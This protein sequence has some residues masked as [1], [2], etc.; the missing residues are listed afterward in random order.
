MARRKDHTREELTQLAI[1]CGREI[2]QA[3]GVNALTARNVAKHMH[4]APGTLYNL[5]ENID[6]LVAAINALTLANL[7]ASIDQVIRAHAKPKKRLRKIADVYMKL[8]LQQPQLWELLL[9]KPTEQKTDLIEAAN[10]GILLQLKEVIRPLSKSDKSAQIEARVF[11]SAL[12]G[13]CLCHTDGMNPNA[14]SLE[15]LFKLFLNQFLNR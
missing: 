3:E 8:H 9:A 1:H 4:Y 10:N 7:E 5:F 12:H 11:L 14:P 6:S 13:I 15:K 2:V